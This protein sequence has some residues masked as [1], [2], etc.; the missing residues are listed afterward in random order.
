[1]ERGGKDVGHLPHSDSGGPGACAIDGGVLRRGGVARR[2]GVRVAG[3]LR[4]VHAGGAQPGYCR[5]GLDAGAAPGGGGGAAVLAA[6]GVAALVRGRSAMAA[7]MFWQ[8]PE[9]EA[10]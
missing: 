1:M 6:G 7:V 5:G 8:L 9:E 4:A 3:R 2:A 10:T